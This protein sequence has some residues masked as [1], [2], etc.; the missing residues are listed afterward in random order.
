MSVPNLPPNFIEP[1]K[2]ADLT[3]EEQEKLLDEIRTRRMIAVTL[4][5]AV[6]EERKKVREVAYQKKYDTVIKRLQGCIDKIDEEITKFNGY[7]GKLR[8]LRLEA[9]D[10]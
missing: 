3:D 10:E 6:M 7:Y 9:F 4:H 8:V 2:L 5:L 1:T